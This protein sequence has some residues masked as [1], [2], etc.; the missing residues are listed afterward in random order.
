MD[1][2]PSP[3]PLP[4]LP[5]FPSSSSSH[6]FFLAVQT[7]L[8]VQKGMSSHLLS[9]KISRDY[10]LHRLYGICRVN[11]V[12]GSW[13]TLREAV[14]GSLFLLTVSWNFTSYTRD[15]GMPF[16][17]ERLLLL[18]VMFPHSHFVVSY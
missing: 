2:L 17:G 16:V 11:H 8:P 1:A 10:K 3:F 18:L 12:R 13:M 5:F 14:Q 9:L 6:S 15:T 4:L 7:L